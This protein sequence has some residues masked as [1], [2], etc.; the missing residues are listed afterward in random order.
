MNTVV[1]ERSDTVTAVQLSARLER[2]DSFWEGPDDVERGYR[3]LGQFYRVNYLQHVPQ[4]RSVRILV[5]SCGPGYFVNMLREEGY[6]VSSLNVRHLNPLPLDI[7]EILTRFK[8]VLVP[9]LN[10][11]QMSMILSPK[12]SR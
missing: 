12:S 8:K 3:T 9:E 6:K 11:G 5:V 4:D 1:N 10:L 7:G 2:F